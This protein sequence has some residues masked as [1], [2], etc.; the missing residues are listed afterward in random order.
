M[1]ITEYR[2]LSEKGREHLEWLD[3][4]EISPG[5]RIM[6]REYVKSL[7]ESMSIIRLSERDIRLPGLGSPDYQSAIMAIINEFCRR[8]EHPVRPVY[9]ADLDDVVIAAAHDFPKGFGV[10]TYIRTG[11]SSGAVIDILPA[12]TGTVSFDDKEIIFVMTDFIDLDPTRGIR[13]VYIQVDGKR[14]YAVPTRVLRLTEIPA[15]R[16]PLE[17]VTNS[18]D[19]DGYLETGSSI[20]A[21]VDGVFIMRYSKYASLLGLI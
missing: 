9:E 6:A 7:L 5:S 3:T 2:K 20:E 21:F 12:A 1:D 19:V 11:L 16:L 17:K 10:D 15:I 14:K 13:E 8:V 18:L 4:Q